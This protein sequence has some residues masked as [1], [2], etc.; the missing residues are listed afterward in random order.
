M[1]WRA[2]DLCELFALSIVQIGPETTEIR[3]SKTKHDSLLLSGGRCPAG[4]FGAATGLKSPL[5]SSE[6]ATASTCPRGYAC[7]SGAASGTAVP[8]GVQRQ[9]AIW[10][11]VEF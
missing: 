11:F 4:R 8:C 5:C 2:T 1:F 10:N 9:A 7:P 3:V 6:N